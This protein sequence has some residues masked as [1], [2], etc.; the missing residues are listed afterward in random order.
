MNTYLLRL[1]NTIHTEIKK[2]GWLTK[3]ILISIHTQD[4]LYH[5]T[6]KYRNTAQLSRHAT[7]C[8]EDRK[9]LSRVIR[10]AKDTL[11]GKSKSDS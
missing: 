5:K 11:F 1:Q 10:A 2:E 6:L 3:G 7:F 8:K 9:I 4:K